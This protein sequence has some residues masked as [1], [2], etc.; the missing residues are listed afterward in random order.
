[1]IHG[2]GGDEEAMWIFRRAI[3]AGVAIITPRAPLDLNQGGY[4]WYRRNGSHPQP[5]PDSLQTGLE[6]LF[7]FLADLAHQ[8]PIDPARLA[9]IGFSQ[10]AVMVNAL[11]ISRPGLAVGAAA[12]S[13]LVPETLLDT[14]ADGSL[15]DLPV[16][17][18]HGR[19]DEIVPLAYA[20]QSRDFYTRQG[21]QVTYGEYNTGHKVTTQAMAALKHW[22]A[23]VMGR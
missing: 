15:T 18:T 9:L 12:L 20:H 23:G 10:G 17:I 3:P 11:V 6:R 13:G 21:A 22:L 14:L 2:W 5:A 1:M 7:R 4:C 16:F 8:Y 19:R